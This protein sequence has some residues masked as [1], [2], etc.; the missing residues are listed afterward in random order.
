M[1]RWLIIKVVCIC[2]CMPVTAIELKDIKDSFVLLS[3]QISGTHLS[4]LNIYVCTERPAYLIRS[5]GNIV[6]YNFMGIRN[7]SDT[8]PHFHTHFIHQ[9]DKIDPQSNKLILILRNYK[10]WFLRYHQG[11]RF[12]CKQETLDPL[13]VIH[14]P[15]LMR[16]Y[17]GYLKKF[18]AWPENARHI[19]H[20]EDLCNN[21]QETLQEL[22][23][24]LGVEREMA[25]NDFKKLETMKPKL[26]KFYDHH[27][28]YYGGSRS[29]R[30]GKPFYTRDIDSEEL[31][32]VDQ[33]MKEMHPKLF[34][35]YLTRYLQ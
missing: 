26:K 21:P 4:L 18:H 2:L 10:E 8:K 25:E 12:S 27:M 31:E 34:K 17:Y 5:G 6:P 14:D 7:Y 3:P 11:Y 13:D 23:R 29:D 1:R 16:L 30:T 15:F 9:V 22:A 20:Y 28:A 32:K 24:F 35:A 33:E 19:V